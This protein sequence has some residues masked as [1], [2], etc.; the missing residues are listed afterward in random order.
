MPIV[1]NISSTSNYSSKSYNI[2][3]AE[4]EVLEVAVVEVALVL[5]VV[6]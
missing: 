5:A 3:M 1:G 4:A 2:V 6:Q